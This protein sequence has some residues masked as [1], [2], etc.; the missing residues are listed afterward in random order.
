MA[1]SDRDTIRET[2]IAEDEPNATDEEVLEEFA[3]AHRP[4]SGGERLTRKL[5]EHHSR[6]PELSGG[7]IDA[8]WDKADVGE[9]TVGGSTP[10][11][12]QDVVEELGEAVG[13]TY[14]DNEPLRGADKIEERDRDRWDFDPASSEDFDD[15]VY[16]DDEWRRRQQGKD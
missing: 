2:N 16:R 12:D 1:Q 13:L 14:E 5:E 9:E 6:T 10:T 11:P 3:K 8:A 7:D 4:V 15:R